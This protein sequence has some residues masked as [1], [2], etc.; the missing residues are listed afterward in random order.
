MADFA[1]GRFRNQLLTVLP[2]AELD[3]LSA[4]LKPVSLPRRTQIEAPNR[5]IEHVYFLESGIISIVAVAPGS[6]I[7]VGVI[8]REGASGLSI[9]HSDDR[10]PYSA[11]MQ[12]AGTGHRIEAE[13]FAE[14]LECNI[15]SRKLFLRWAHAFTLQTS[16]TAAANAR[17]TILERLA[18]RLL[19]AQDRVETNEIPLTHEFLATMMGVRRPG[20]TEACHRLAR[21]GLIDN[22]R[23]TI[24]VADRKGLQQYAGHFYGVFENEYARLLGVSISWRGSDSK[25][26]SGP[27]TATASPQFEAL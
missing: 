26:H 6:E 23:G 7:E 5:P 1:Q 19:M 2:T 22:R 14:F 17:A 11:Y 20:V 24:I 3:F 15:A 4:S 21:L 10:G 18:R 27:N 9:I 12:V 13:A 16:E 25:A 8:G